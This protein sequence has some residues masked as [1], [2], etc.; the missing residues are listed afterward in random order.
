MRRIQPAPDKDATIKANISSIY[1]ILVAHV[2]LLN[3]G[4]TNCTF[5]LLALIQSLIV[6]SFV[7]IDF[8]I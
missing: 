8:N 1:I 6:D 7:H 5:F 3:A 2:Q 4:L